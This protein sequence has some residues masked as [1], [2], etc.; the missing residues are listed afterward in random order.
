MA[1]PVVSQNKMKLS[2]FEMVRTL[3]TGSFGRVKFAKSRTD[4]QYYAVKFMKKHDII[5]L[6]Q[7]TLAC[8]LAFITHGSGSH[9]RREI[10]YAAA[11]SSVHCK[12]AWV[13]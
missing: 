4:G 6:K 7:G 8:F 13:V 1:S 10:N 5:K 9:Q 3:G 11:E 12:Y 2:D